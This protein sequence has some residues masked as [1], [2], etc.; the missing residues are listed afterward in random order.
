MEG[1][2]FLALF[3]LLSGC[4]DKANDGEADDSATSDDTSTP[5]PALPTHWETLPSMANPR[6]GLGC[7]AIGDDVYAI[8]GYGFASDPYRRDLEVLSGGEWIT[9]SDMSTARDYFVTAPRTDG[10]FIVV[11][12]FSESA[13]NTILGYDPA[14][15]GWDSAGSIASR[16]FPSGGAISGDR[17]VIAGGAYNF[18]GVVA[19][20]TIIDFAGGEATDVTPAPSAFSWAASATVGDE[21]YVSGGTTGVFTLG[22]RDDLLV[23]DAVGDT[24]TAL[25]PLPGGAVDGHAMVA[26]H[27]HLSSS[28]ATRRLA[29]RSTRSGGTTSRATPGRQRT[30]FPPPSPRRARSRSGIA[31]W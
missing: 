17:V 13:P 22:N 2:M 1:T 26:L 18:N 23:Y 7:V 25:A 31:P 15:D 14:T 6:N 3:P 16:M 24:W 27:D 30:R 12:G 9:K 19:D 8:A 10:S 29:T 4:D 5:P 11:G 28:A 21:L 20:T